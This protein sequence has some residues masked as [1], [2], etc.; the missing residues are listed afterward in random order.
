MDQ[1]ADRFRTQ[2]DLIARLDMLEFRG[3]RAVLYFDRVEFKFFVPRRRSDR[4]GAQQ[5]LLLACFGMGV[6]HQTDHHKLAGTK[7]Q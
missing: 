4:V 6:A 5:R 3:Q 7:A 2:D 1:C